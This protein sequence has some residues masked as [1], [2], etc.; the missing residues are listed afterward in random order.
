MFKA[1]LNHS[2]SSLAIVTGG[3][4]GLGRATATLLAKKGA[5]VILVDLPTSDGRK[6]AASLSAE[7]NNKDIAFISADILNSDEVT[8]ALDHARNLFKREINIVVNCAGIAIAKKT[9][10][11][12]DPQALNVHDLESFNKIITVNVAGTFN[13]NRLASQRMAKNEPNSDGQRGVIINTASV[14]AYDGQ[15]GQVAYASSK[16]AIVAMTLPLARDLAPFGIRVCTIAPGVFRTP[17]VASLP[18]AVQDVLGKQVPFPN[19]LGNPEEYAK[20]VESII[21]NPFLNVEVIR[22]DGALR[23]PQK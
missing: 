9:L 19:R 16:G 6:V 7:S 10:S 17:M 15:I 8:K 11:G 14:A 22:I 23:M 2:L 12:K 13:V 1:T 5:G 20:L 4:S 21:D 18:P 3:A